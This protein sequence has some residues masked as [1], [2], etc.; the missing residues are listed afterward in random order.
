MQVVIENINL[1]FIQLI[2]HMLFLCAQKL[3]KHLMDAV[4]LIN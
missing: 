4:I 2:V 1:F 3:K